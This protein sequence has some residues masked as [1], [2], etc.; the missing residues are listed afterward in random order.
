MGWGA[1]LDDHEAGTAGLGGGEVHA[2]AL[3]ARDV[4][5]LDGGLRG[6][7][8]GERGGEFELH[9]CGIECSTVR[10]LKLLAAFDAVNAHANPIPTPEL[11]SPSLIPISP[12]HR[13]PIR[14]REH[15]SVLLSWAGRSRGTEQI[16]GRL[17]VHACSHLPPL[18]DP[19][20][21]PRGRRCG[22]GP[23]RLGSR[24]W[25]ARGPRRGSPRGLAEDR[26]P[27]W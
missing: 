21:R 6:S 24:D 18:A 5:A 1:H 17:S 9:D 23:L 27:I 25:W 16:A 13:H 19:Q 22:L 11:P 12:P 15:S 4:K 14:N 8:Q 26:G 3:V 2:G 20:F 7:C 10:V